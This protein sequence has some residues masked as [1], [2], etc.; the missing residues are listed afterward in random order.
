MEEEPQTTAKP[1]VV[2]MD[3]T[4]IATDVLA[5]GV[6]AGFFAKPFSTL[7]AFPL[8]LRGRA[9]FKRRIAAIDAA[10]IEAAPLRVDVV[11]W[12]QGEKARGRAL[13]L[14]SAADETL[15]KRV[16]DRV[17]VFDTVQGSR[18]GENLKSG[19]KAAALKKRFPEGYVYAGD[20]R[21]DLPVW[22][23]AAGIVTVA[24]RA[25]LK[26]RVRAMPVPVER[27]FAAPPGGLGVWRRA[28]RMHQW[29]K[30]LLVFVPLM[31]SGSFRDPQA[32]L[33]AIAAF[34]L[35]SIAASGTYLLNDLADLGADRRHRSKHTR[36][37]ASGAIPVQY[38]AIAALAMIAGTLL[39][40][41]LISPP[42]AAVLATYL[43]VTLSYSFHF[44]RT[45]FLDVFL[46]GVLYT[47]RLVLGSAVLQITYSEWL[48]SFAMM[49]FFS[50][51][52]A[53]RH[54]EVAASP[55][56][57]IRG[58]GYRAEDAPL[59]LAFGVA[60]TIG[61]VLIMISYLMEEAF[62]SGLYATPH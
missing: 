22:K 57:P 37:L 36:P 4:L 6:I 8:L 49:F 60:S 1:L 52:L 18:D 9:H 11:E 13:H 47:L 5:E 34:A 14:V 39:V 38:G 30:N 58:R 51:S 23:G 40:A 35:L 43:V 55:S 32:I 61:S 62:P 29:S 20:S 48:L 16:A 59:T 12:L 15:A 53:K 24:A 54:V 26:R 28:L 46:L 44:K 2:D 33:A 42:A 19:R 3:G 10:D 7:S 41:G 31:L 25:G 17:C 21:A 27:E 56:G 50:L 45:P